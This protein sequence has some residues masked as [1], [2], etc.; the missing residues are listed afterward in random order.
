VRKYSLQL[1][2]VEEVQQFLETQLAL[3]EFGLVV[4]VQP[5]HELVERF[6]RGVCF[7]RVLYGL[8]E[9]GG[10]WRCGHAVHTDQVADGLVL[11]LRELVSEQLVLVLQGGENDYLGGGVEDSSI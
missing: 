9:E 3:D 8:L 11:V 5:G 1:L 4:G 2:E 6:G 7:R 10:H